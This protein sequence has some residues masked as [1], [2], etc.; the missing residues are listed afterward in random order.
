LREREKESL[1]DAFGEK[2][3]RMNSIDAIS[4]WTKPR[5]TESTYF[6]EEFSLLHLEFFLVLLSTLG[7]GLV[8][9][10]LA[11]QTSNLQ[12]NQALIP[13]A[14]SSLLLLPPEARATSSKTHNTSSLY[15]IQSTTHVRLKRHD[16]LFRSLDFG[17]V[18]SDES[19]VFLCIRSIE[20]GI[21]DE[22]KRG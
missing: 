11:L 2:I 16:F 6:P 9:R 20:D 1:L 5:Q 4:T 3:A 21:H 13:V 12:S 10:H 22:N 7:C 17:F 8:P 14:R 15:Q 19:V 18:L